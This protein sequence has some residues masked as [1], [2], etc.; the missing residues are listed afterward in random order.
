MLETDKLTEDAIR[1][2]VREEIKRAFKKDPATRKLSM[3]ASKGTLD[4]AYPPLILA[5]AGAA[6]GTPDAAVVVAS[7]MS[8][9]RTESTSAQP[10]GKPC[11]WLSGAPSYLPVQIQSSTLCST[12][13]KA[14]WRLPRVL[15]RWRG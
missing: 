6:A 15:V 9:A 1:Q 13:T 3:V 12:R 10:F 14:A 11:D 7:S 4:W 2:I 8:S 5:T